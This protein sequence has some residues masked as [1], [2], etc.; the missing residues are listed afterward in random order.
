MTPQK[1]KNRKGYLEK[2]F[3]LLILIILGLNILHARASNPYNLDPDLYKQSCE[4]TVYLLRNGNF[5]GSGFITT[6]KSTASYI[7]TCYHVTQDAGISENDTLTVETILNNTMNFHHGIVCQVNPPPYDISLIAITDTVLHGRGIPTKLYAVP[8][9][10]QFVVYT[11][12]PGTMWVRTESMKMPLMRS[13]RI[14]YGD[15]NS[16]QF[17]IDGLVSQGSSGSPVFG[18][19]EADTFRFLGMIDAA[20]V[21]STYRAFKG[22][23]LKFFDLPIGIGACI[24]AKAIMEKLDQI[25]DFR[26]YFQKLLKEEKK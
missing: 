10:G 12:F 19:D 21:D 22:D 20:F 2:L 4:A 3:L 24:S 26:T 1:V 25:E 17:L 11:G 18:Y 5:I 8:F 9:T 6:Y 15:S 7:V 23:T 16:V 14:A 13:A